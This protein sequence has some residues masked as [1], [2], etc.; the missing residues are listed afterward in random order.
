MLKLIKKFLFGNKKEVKKSLK[1]LLKRQ[2]FKNEHNDVFSGNYINGDVVVSGGGTVTINGVKQKRSKVSLGKYISQ[3]REITSFDKIELSGVVNVSFEQAQETSVTVEAEENIIHQIITTIK[4][5]TLHISTEGNFYATK[6]IK[7]KVKS[8]ELISVKQS[9]VTS[10]IAKN[11]KSEHF[12]F[13][14]K[15]TGKATLSG[16][17]ITADFEIDGVGSFN[18]KDFKVD[19]LHIKKGGVGSIYLFAKKTIKGSLSGVGSR[20]IYG[21][22]RNSGLKTSG[23]G[24]TTYY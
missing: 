11:L 24:S 14:F 22:P 16:S 9:G 4:D 8:P 12:N 7:I 21:N 10:F 13:R 6:T 3:Q 20:H 18:A 23:V 5:N 1:D 17:A 15:S 2:K 19:D